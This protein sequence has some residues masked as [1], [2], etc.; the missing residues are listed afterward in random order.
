M[1]SIFLYLHV[2][3]EHYYICPHCWENAMEANA[4]TTTTSG[5]TYVHNPGM[6]KLCTMFFRDDGAVHPKGKFCS[7]CKPRLAR[8]DLGARNMR[9]QGWSRY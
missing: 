4:G 6:G 3:I 9:L 1:L 8:A 7:E 5:K 2:M